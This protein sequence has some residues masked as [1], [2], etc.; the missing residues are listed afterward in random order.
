MLD[1]STTLRP[2]LNEQYVFAD[3]YHALGHDK[4]SASRRWNKLPIECKGRGKIEG[5]TTEFRTITGPGLLVYLA[6]EGSMDSIDMLAKSISSLWLSQSIDKS[7]PK[8]LSSVEDN[9]IREQ[10]LLSQLK[11]I[12][13]DG[14]K[15][16]EQQQEK[17]DRANKRLTEREKQL[18]KSEELATYAMNLKISKDARIQALE[19]EVKRLEEEVSEAVKNST[20]YQ[21]AEANRELLGKLDNLQ[22]DSKRIIEELEIKVA[23]L[24]KRML[25]KEAECLT[26]K[27][28]NENLMS[29][30]FD[31]GGEF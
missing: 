7:A 5:K 27:Q 19:D 15:L 24:E 21:L 22:A 11:Q 25:K 31:L 18:K 8:A 30:I 1:I 14:K 13:E 10:E 4:S 2:T 20:N 3:F 23:N 12:E 17:L 16:S 6:L 28:S 26:L 29:Q 9:V